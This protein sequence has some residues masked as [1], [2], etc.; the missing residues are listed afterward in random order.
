MLDELEKAAFDRFMGLQVPARYEAQ[1]QATIAR[2]E[3]VRE[4]RRELDFRAK[5][6]VR[7]VKPVV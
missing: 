6:S 3:A 5:H 4:I 7:V 2:I 1:G